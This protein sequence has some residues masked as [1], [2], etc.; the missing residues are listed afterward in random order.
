MIKYGIFF[1]FVLLSFNSPASNELEQG[2]GLFSGKDGEFKL[3]KFSSNKSQNE[4]E[5]S[6][7]KEFQLYLQWLKE[8]EQETQEYKEF[9]LWIKY[10][11]M[12]EGN[13]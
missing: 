10:V 3:L 7:K 9:R 6:D 11:A 8:K 1:F 2:P 4:R 5:L 12:K 13:D